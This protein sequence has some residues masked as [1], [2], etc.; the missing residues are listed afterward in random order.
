M[1]I[2]VVFL[3][4]LG[5]CGCQTQSPAP[6]KETPHKHTGE[7]AQVGDYRFAS[8]NVRNLFD[9]VDDPNSDEVLT[10]E[11]YKE[12]LQ[13]LAG[14]IDEIN[15][16]F[17]GLQEVENVGTLKELNSVLARPFPQG[18]LIEGNDKQRGIDVAFLSRIPVE[19]VISHADH[20]LPTHPDTPPRYHFSRDCLEVQLKTVPPTTVLVNHLKSQRGDA[21]KSAAK[22]YVQAEGI[23]EVATK[24]DEPV[25][26]AIVVLGDLNDREDSW[27]L[28]PVFKRFNDAF[29][30]MPKSERYT[31]RYRKENSALDHILLDADAK[32]IAGKSKIW[33]EIARQT[34]DHSPVSVQMS[35]KAAKEKP[36]EKFWTRSD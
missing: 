15:P 9:T 23:L 24:A 5:L 35:L 17:I 8:W 20:V 36:G 34:S 12:K 26:R 33:K 10:P 32:K 18:G 2:L 30:G 11:R 3:L 31:H 1:K 19:R 13:E 25:S 21:K 28:E 14:V 29:E 27:A 6:V 7:S 22:R 4:L 16:D